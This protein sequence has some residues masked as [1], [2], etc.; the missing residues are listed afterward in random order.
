[1]IYIL[2]ADKISFSSSLYF[3]KYFLKMYKNN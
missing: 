2:L 1:M 3:V